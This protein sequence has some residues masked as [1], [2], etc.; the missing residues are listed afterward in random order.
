[1]LDQLCTVV[2]Y[3]DARNKPARR[4]GRRPAETARNKPARRIG[5]LVKRI[6]SCS[7]R[8]NLLADWLLRRWPSNTHE[9][10]GSF[11]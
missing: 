5:R 8:L 2:A 10:F 3:E 1:M 11:S 4:I 6:S 9:R 7:R